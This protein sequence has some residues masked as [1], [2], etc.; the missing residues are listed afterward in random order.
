MLLQG[1]TNRA[2]GVRAADIERNFVQFMRGQ[3]GPPQNK[4][5]LGTVAVGHNDVPAILDERHDMMARLAGGKVLIAHGL[6]VFIFNERIATDGIY[7]SN[8]L[9]SGKKMF[10]HEGCEDHEE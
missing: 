1:V 2:L 5:D 6:V 8:F 10:N 9:H 4:T 7:S 3:L